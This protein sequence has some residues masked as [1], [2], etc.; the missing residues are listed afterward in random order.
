MYKHVYVRLYVGGR[1][2]TRIDEKYP[3]V[4]FRFSSREKCDRF[5]KLCSE[6]LGIESR[7]SCAHY[8]VE[9][10]MADLICIWAAQRLRQLV[11]IMEKI[12]RAAPSLR[13]HLQKIKLLGILPPSLDDIDLVEFD[14]AIQE[15]AEAVEETRKML[16]DLERL[17]K[18]YRVRKPV[19]PQAQV[20]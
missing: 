15:A 5:E 4:F 9:L 14:K 17:E 3:G 12:L 18:T 2:K 20:C 1:K 8:L 6:V 13:R 10:A 19:P 7:G 11:K 16:R